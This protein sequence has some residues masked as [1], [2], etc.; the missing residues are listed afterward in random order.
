MSRIIRNTARVYIALALGFIYLP[1]LI[2]MLMAFNQSRINQFPLVFDLIWFQKL[3]QNQRLIRATANSIGIA[4][5]TSVL[6]TICATFAALVLARQQFRG[7]AFLQALLLPPITIPWII[8]AVA[9]LLTFFWLGVSR[10]IVTLLLGHVTVQI[11]FAIIVISARLAATDR[12]LEDAAASLGSKPARTFRTITLPLMLP[13]VLAALIFS[14]A[15]SFDNFPISYF[16]APAGV[17]TLPVE[18]YTAIRTGFTPEVNA[19]STLV[20]VIS[21]ACALVGGREISF[22]VRST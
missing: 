14:F 18:I 9:L 4:V 16:L 21:A 6:A 11:P 7:K 8:L 5:L 15:V 10:S 22:G 1:L 3:A 19:I 2:M 17:S 20:F 12:T 13:G